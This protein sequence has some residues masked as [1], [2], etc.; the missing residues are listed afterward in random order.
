[1]TEMLTKRGFGFIEVLSPCPT[2]YQRCN[3]MGDGLDAH[4]RSGAHQGR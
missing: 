2:L 4:Q 1:M 3:K